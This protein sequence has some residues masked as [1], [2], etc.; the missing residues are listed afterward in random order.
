MGSCLQIYQLTFA[1]VPC[2][3]N[4]RQVNL[5]LSSAVCVAV[6]LADSTGVRRCGDVGGVEVLPRYVHNPPCVG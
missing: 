6:A 5:R 1:V 3:L 2:S 4:D